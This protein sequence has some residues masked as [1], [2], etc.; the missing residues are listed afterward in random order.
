MLNVSDPVQSGLVASLAQPG[1][2]LTGVAN[3]TRELYGFR[4]LTIHS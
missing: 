3:L 4:S 1:G 2:N